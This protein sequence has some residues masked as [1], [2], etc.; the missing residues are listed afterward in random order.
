IN[1]QKEVQTAN[2]SDWSTIPFNFSSSSNAPLANVTPATNTFTLLDDA[3]GHQNALGQC[4]VG[5]H[6]FTPGAPAQLLVSFPVNA[7]GNYPASVAVTVSELVAAGGAAGAPSNWNLLDVRCI[8]LNP[9]SQNPNLYGVNPPLSGPTASFNIGQ[10]MVVTCTFRNSPILQVTA[11]PASV[12]GKVTTASGDAIKNVTVTLTE[13]NAGGVVLTT[14][15]N[16]AGSYKFDHVD[17]EKAYRVSI[18]AQKKYS[19]STDYQTFTLLGDIVVNFTSSN[20]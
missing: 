10:F 17:T 3:P 20:R 1:V 4:D 18:S 2:C 9:S 11:A 6:D 16:G 15:T 13:L 5:G 19:F 8:D 12:T 14:T 7:Q